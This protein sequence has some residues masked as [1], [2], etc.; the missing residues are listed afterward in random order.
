MRETVTPAVREKTVWAGSNLGSFPQASAA[1]EALA[2]VSVSAQRVRRITEQVG[3]DRLTERREEV[4][5]FRDRPLMERVSSPAGVA[6]P[7]LGVVM[8]DGGRYQRRDHFGLAFLT[9]VTGQA[10]D[11]TG[12][13]ERH[14]ERD[15]FVQIAADADVDVVALEGDPRKAGSFDLVA[16]QI[17]AAHRE[18]TGATRGF[19]SGLFFFGDQTAHGGSIVVGCFTVLIGG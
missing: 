2:G 19:V 15:G 1:L 11:F 4:A 18:R 14:G 5:E 16:D 17:G 9:H 8:M 3:Q 7:E 13:A 6:A 12:R 10:H